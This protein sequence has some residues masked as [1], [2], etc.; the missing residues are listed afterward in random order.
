[1]LGESLCFVLDPASG[2][3]FYR[4]VIQLIERAILAGRL[5]PGDRLPTIRALAVELKINPNTIA[6]A[7]GELE[8]RGI[9]ATQVG[10]GTFVSERPDDSAQDE[11]EKKIAELVLRFMRDMRDLGLDRERIAAVINEYREET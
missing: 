5:R 6:K 2:V 9:V 11:L 7:Y 1:M 3:P 10:S 8:L 4:Q